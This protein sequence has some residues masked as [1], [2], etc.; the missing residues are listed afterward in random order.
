MADL[1]PSLR[2]SSIGGRQNIRD[3]RQQQA[4]I[5]AEQEQN[6]PS[7]DE[8]W[9]AA[10]QRNFL[11]KSLDKST[12]RDNAD[13]DEGYRVSKDMLD[14]LATD[15]DEKELSF[16][17]KAVSP[18]DFR[19]RRKAVARNR[20]NFETIQK[21]GISGIGAEVLAGVVD[22]T[23]L[24]MMLATGGTAAAAK[25]GLLSRTL[26]AFGSGA[27]V[28]AGAE[29]VLANNDTTKD[30]HDVGLAAISGGVVSGAVPAAVRGFQGLRGRGRG[31]VGTG[32]VRDPEAWDSAKAV[33]S[34]LLDAAQGARAA[35]L[36]EEI[37]RH[38]D[39]TLINTR[40]SRQT[41]ID[42]LAPEAEL[43]MS[44]GVRKEDAQRVSSLEADIQ[45]M[46]NEDTARRM[47]MDAGLTNRKRK[48]N[49]ADNARMQGELDQRVRPLQD[50]IDSIRQRQADDARFQEAWR[51][52]S[53]LNNGV[54]PER[55]RDRF[56]ELEEESTTALNRAEREA[57]T[58][59]A[60]QD[61]SSRTEG[62]EAEAE[63]TPVD[64]EAAV[65]T[66]GAAQTRGAQFADE[67]HLVDESGPV[68][69]V[70][71]DGV[72]LAERMPA[73]WQNRL[74]PG[75]RTKD[76]L[77]STFTTLDAAPSNILR[78]LNIKLNANP[79]AG[80]KGHIPAAHYQD[81][82]MRR[83]INSEGGVE[84][85]AVLEYAK[86]RGVSAF[87]ME[88]GIAPERAAF[89]NSVL[90][91]M[92]GKVLSEDPA[93][94]KASKA[95]A[96]MLKQSLE[97]RKAAGVHGF[98][99]VGHDERY[100]PMV[101]DTTKMQAAY[102]THGE[103]AVEDTLTG[104]YQAGRMKL[105]ERSARMI[106]RA[107]MRRTLDKGLD[108]QTGIRQM[109]TEA[110]RA[111]LSQELKAQGMDDAAVDRL[112]DDMA[113]VQLNESVSKRAKFSLG[114]SMS[115]ENNGL[116]MVDLLNSSQDVVMN[117]ARE[118]AG[119]ASL[120]RQGFKTRQQA[121][122]AID[123]AL[124]DVRGL[125]QSQLAD[126]KRKGDRDEVGRLTE[127]LGDQNDGKLKHYGEMLHNSVRLPD[128]GALGP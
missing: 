80:L 34:D 32:V 44:R 5:E 125:M 106:A 11:Y 71:E 36:G 51:D 85:E 62:P 15:Y 21:A 14:P 43:R 45:R 16:V 99:D 87:K 10:K 105:G 3:T 28:S 119:E 60:D 89:D 50:E 113:D 107:Q 83:A 61:R 39:N 1:I 27:A 56:E 20:K 93:V 92:R 78:G 69:E 109:F 46:T 81:M 9:E 95:R 67:M 123:E 68:A 116:R 58:T 98:E 25:A 33:D 77:Q 13:P 7:W 73:N 30:W 55:L 48:L 4:A 18:E 26:R 40:S 117:Y 128:G 35:D 66:V 31:S 110:N 53:R 97:D 23:M 24:P 38:A 76:Y 121:D 52:I 102:R 17:A 103:K 91:H 74:L 79:Q 90:L 12:R 96:A 101:M 124:R 72:R 54:V 64:T 8:T 120:A 41:L 63:S 114:A 75:Q 65:S 126:A 127:E 47:P 111:H 118:G 115:Y 6:A 86:A 22:P 70:L 88:M 42:E 94:Q 82:Y 108:S 100:F 112:I 49:A 57:I 2:P 104:A 122:E 37:Q 29:T 84:R 59:K 19:E